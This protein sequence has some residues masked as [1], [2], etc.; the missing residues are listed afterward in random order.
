MAGRLK[1]LLVGVGGQGVLTA[2]RHL[3][4]AARLSGR[5]VVLGQLHGMSQRGGSVESTVLIGY[6]GSSFIEE[7]EADIVLALEPLEAKRARPRMRSS[8]IVLTSTKPVVPLLLSQT[9][10]PY[11]EIASILDS[12][13]TVTSEVIAIDGDRI[14]REAGSLRSLNIAMLGALSSLDLLPFDSAFLW[15]TIAASTSPRFLDSNLRAFELGS[16]SPSPHSSAS[17]QPESRPNPTT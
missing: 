13:R 12:I 2:A 1:I 5:D 3:G 6:R 17:L 10:Q 15:K 7:G 8:T 4:E 14:V 9:G 16:C 11:P